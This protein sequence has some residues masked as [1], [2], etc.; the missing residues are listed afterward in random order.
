MTQV[1]A[2][3]ENEDLG[4]DGKTVL[5]GVSLSVATGER[6][7]LL[8]KSGAGKSTLLTTI[9]SRLLGRIAYVPQD[10]GL[11]G[12]LSAFHNVWMGRL[13]NHGT[14]RNLRT[15]IW[16]S[17]AERAAVDTVLDATGLSGLGRRPVMNLSGGQKQRVALSR[18][19]LRG[20]DVVLADEPV[21]AVD[22]TQ[23]AELL[24]RL[25]ETFATSVIAMHDVEMAKGWAT[26]IIGIAGGRI[27]LDCPPTEAS[28]ADIAA[29]YA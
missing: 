2:T 4:W 12:Q 27:V 20:G 17:K 9:Y 1:L 23:G 3:L 18:A 13:D 24:A 10:T 25:D 19:L 5:A 11:V 16:P 29:L 14:A 21:S 28:D 7:A 6:L 22:V 26:R 15:L 8:G